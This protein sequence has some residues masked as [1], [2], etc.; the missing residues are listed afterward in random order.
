VARVNG[1][2]VATVVDADRMGSMH[3]AYEEAIGA[4]S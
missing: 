2:E 4:A 3:K 1:V